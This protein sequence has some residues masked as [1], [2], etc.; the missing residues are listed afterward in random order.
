MKIQLGRDSRDCRVWDDDGVEVDKI[1]KIVLTAEVNKITTV[2]I[3]RFL[4]ESD[5]VEAEA[6]E[7][8]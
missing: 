4:A 2:E 5:T 8:V 7:V 6:E 1:T 3:T